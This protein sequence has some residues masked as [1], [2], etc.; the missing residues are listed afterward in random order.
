MKKI[1]EIMRKLGSLHTML[2]HIELVTTDKAV[3]LEQALNRAACERDTFMEQ[4]DVMLAERNSLLAENEKLRAENHALEGRLRHLL[5]SE[6]IRLFDEMGG[7]FYKRDI[8]L[9]DDYGVHRR[10]VEQERAV[11]DKT[12]KTCRDKDCDIL[13]EPCASCH[14]C[15]KWEP[16]A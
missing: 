2:K 3:E 13:F 4:R 1:D 9:L 11:L 5:Q 6:T 8:A 14:H 7:R 12:C 16:K 15:E 10:I